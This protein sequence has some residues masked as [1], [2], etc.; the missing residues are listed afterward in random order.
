MYIISAFVKRR[1]LVTFFML[2]Y[3]LTWPLVPLFSVS[4]VF[5]VLGLFGPALAAIAVTAISEGRTGVKAL[6]GRVVEWRLGSFWYVVAVG[7]PVALTLAMVE[8]EGLLGGAMLDGPGDPP[9]LIAILA[10]LVIG[11]EIGWRGFALPRLQARF[12]G[13]GASLILGLLW[14]A[15]HLANA[16]IPGLERYWYAFPAFALF[17]VAQ[18]ILFTWIANHTRGSVLLAWLFH[19]AINVAGSRFAIGDPVRQWWLSAAAFG[20]VALIVLVVLGPNLT[21]RS[22]VHAKS[23]VVAP[24]GRIT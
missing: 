9:A 1:P 6:L 5:P 4:L 2:A 16:T 15:W 17:V 11:E 20:V 23:G 13:L 19:A 8:L 14:A 22:E 18:T 24:E 10:L 12:G 7:L 3:A 21:Q